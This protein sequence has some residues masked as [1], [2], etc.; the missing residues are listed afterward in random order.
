MNL[1]GITDVD[2]IAMYTSSVMKLAGHDERGKISRDEW[3]KEWGSIKRLLGNDKIPFKN[4][5]F[6]S[7][8]VY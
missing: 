2:A 6:L 1:W 7:L 8:P 3:T 5:T 4:L